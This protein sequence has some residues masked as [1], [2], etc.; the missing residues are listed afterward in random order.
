[1][2]GDRPGSSPPRRRRLGSNPP[3]IY[4]RTYPVRRA[5]RH[6][7]GRGSCCRSGA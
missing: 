3:S 5:R 4:K 6:R 7:C 1:M 2:V